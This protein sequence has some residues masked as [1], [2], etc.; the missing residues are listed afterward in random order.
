M[1]VHEEREQQE[2][3]VPR[4][5][6]EHGVRFEDESKLAEE[7]ELRRA[8]ESDPE[9]EQVPDWTPVYDLKENREY[10]FCDD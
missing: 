7:P 8:A 5:K 10:T 9:L 2:S 3:E 4:S 6:A 1:P